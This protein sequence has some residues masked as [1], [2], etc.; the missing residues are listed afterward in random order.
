METK[1]KYFIY[2]RKSEEDEKR[3]ILSIEA[4]LRELKEYAQKCDLHIVEVLTESKSAR[5]PG[6]ET[7]NNMLRRIEVGEA[8]AMLVWQINRIARNHKDG[9]NVLQMITDGVIKQV[10]TPHKQFKNTGDDKFFMAL[11][12]GMATKFSDDLSDNIRRGNKAKYE[13][14]E[15]LGVAPIGYLNVKISGHP[16]IALDP[17][18]APLVKRVFEEYSTGNYS[19]GRMCELIKS[20]GLK[21]K[22]D[23]PI[24]KS[25]LQK[26]LQKEA[27]YG[28]YFHGGELHNGTY[29]KLIERSLFDRVQDVL[30]NRSKPKKQ[31]NQWAY[32][33]LIKCGC[34]CGASVIFETKQ[35]YY[36]GTDRHVDYTYARS[37]KRCGPCLEQG[38]S[39]IKLEKQFVE[40]AS[41]IE[42]D[43]EQWQLG[44]ELL[45]RKYHHVA[46][47]RAVIVEN[48][49]REYQRI[50]N[51]LDG[52][53]RMRARD[54]I[55]GEEFQVKK[56][57][58]T[59]EQIK[60]KEKIDEGLHNQRY[61][62]ELAQ[63]FLD[64]AY[65][66]RK[67]L[68][69]GTL[70]EK[71]ELIKKIGWNLLLKDGK[72]SWKLQEPYDILL[73]P[74]YRSDVSRGEDSNLRRDKPVRFTV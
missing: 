52:Y 47:E 50:Q 33:G 7:F 31:Y 73:Q 27:Y 32:A 71:R 60:L 57:G 37:S 64:T 56:D 24:S 72:L 10:D 6:R 66:A 22:R 4:Q 29:E 2:C 49:Q 45:N 23:L 9:G 36:K 39:L 51:E 20:L 68:E 61:W 34:G 13:R 40:I 26:I 53:F 44:K 28:W 38:T 65:Y 8:N 48:M 58:L 1:L 12:F 69:E 63:D 42:I 21:T 3:Q 70:D 46:K 5:T 41:N 16:T 14:G 55:I 11:E 67:T 59:K 30:H 19:L 54:E 35:K 25:H 17:E 15:Y 43:E 74:V 62:L 18:K